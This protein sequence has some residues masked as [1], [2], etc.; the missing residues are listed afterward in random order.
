MTFI[1]PYHIGREKMTGLCLDFQSPQF[2]FL[3]IMISRLISC[4][5]NLLFFVPYYILRFEK[6]LKEIDEQE[7]ELQKLVDDYKDIYNRLLGREALERI[8]YNY[9]HDLL[10]LTVRL[11]RIVS[12]LN[13]R[14][15]LM[16]PYVSTIEEFESKM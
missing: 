12:I 5:K 4:D 15:L 3:G 9:L 10:S 6:R 8:D 2:C 14:W 13:V 7:L 1:L 16:A 11:I